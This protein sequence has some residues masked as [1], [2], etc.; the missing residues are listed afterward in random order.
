MIRTLL[1]AAVAL[2][3]L[4]ACTRTNGLD[5][6]DFVSGSDLV[7]SLSS[8]SAL[9]GEFVDVHV[10]TTAS[11]SHRSQLETITADVQIGICFIADWQVV[12]EDGTPIIASCGDQSLYG[13]DEY[14]EPAAVF[15]LATGD[16][17]ALTI[18]FKIDRGQTVEIEHSFRVAADRATTARMVGRLFS[19]RSSRS[20]PWGN[21][22]C[23]DQCG[24]VT[25]E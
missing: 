21:W 18:P 2:F 1:Y 20:L 22:A 9:V 7:V 10:S 3:L 23:L 19:F 6:H 12:A 24:Y 11:L 25:W 8:P 17:A 5:D 16:T 15:T 14:F 13:T 4:A